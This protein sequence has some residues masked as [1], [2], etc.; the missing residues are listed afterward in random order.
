MRA[1]HPVSESAL[2]Q[3]QCVVTV[4]QTRLG[5]SNDICVSFLSILLVDFEDTAICWTNS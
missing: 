2:S 3:S 1:S 4:A 5:N